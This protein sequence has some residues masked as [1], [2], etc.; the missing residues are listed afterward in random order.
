VLQTLKQAVDAD[1]RK[2]ATPTDDSSGSLIPA[3][4]RAP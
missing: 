3:K 2:P 1:F 4:E